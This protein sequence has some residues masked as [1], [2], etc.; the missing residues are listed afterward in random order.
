M[1]QRDMVLI[2]L[3]LVA[4]MLLAGCTSSSSSPSYIATFRVVADSPITQQ[5]FVPGGK[6]LNLQI[7]AT[8]KNITNVT[9]QL[10]F[11]DD[12]GDGCP[13]I[14]GLEVDSPFP[15]A[16][17]LPTQAGESNQSMTINVTIQHLPHEKKSGSKTDLQD[18]L[19]GV[20][21]TQGTGKWTI[22]ISDV[23]ASPCSHPK[24]TDTGNSWVLLIDTFHFEG[25]ITKLD[26]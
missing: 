18:Y 20:V 7:E 5:G 15:D 10:A 2:A 9:V 1:K 8:I 13:D 17:Y 24:T 19:D 11:Y 14:M 23:T 25:N 3:S 22:S 4:I 26:S 12:S 6:T 16:L 21:N